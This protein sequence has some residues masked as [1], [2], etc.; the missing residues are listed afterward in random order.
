MSVICEM[1]GMEINMVNLPRATRDWLSIKALM[2]S[3]YLL[4]MLRPS[5]SPGRSMF[6]EGMR[7]RREAA[8]WSLDRKREWI[9]QRLRFA[10]R[11][12][13]RETVYYRE[14]FDRTGFDPL[15]DF[16]F[17]DFSRLPALGREDVRRAG[18]QL[19]SGDVPPDRLR[20]DATGGSSGTP[21]EIWMGP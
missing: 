2:P 16:S 17:E 6:F 7:F 9:L 13:Y 18:R 5:I 10:V 1:K 11:R 21:T 12:A 20:R 8:A 3:M 4:H 15:A 19:I 14:L